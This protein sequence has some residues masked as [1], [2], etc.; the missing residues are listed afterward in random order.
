M[1][2]PQALQR[3]IYCTKRSDW[4]EKKLHIICIQL[5]LANQMLSASSGA[6]ARF[7][8]PMLT[9]RKKPNRTEKETRAI[10]TTKALNELKR[11]LYIS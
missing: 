3:A 11:E 2:T 9:A 4:R 10:S 6:L 7:L 1:V 5:E 8:C